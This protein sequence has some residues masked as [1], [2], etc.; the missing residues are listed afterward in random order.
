MARDS[1]SAEYA[2]MMRIAKPEEEIGGAAF[3]AAPAC[4]IG[5][6]FTLKRWSPRQLI[7]ASWE[8][9]DGVYGLGFTIRV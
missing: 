5:T 2:A 3:V 6:D 4:G 7:K 9:G 8:G 1:V